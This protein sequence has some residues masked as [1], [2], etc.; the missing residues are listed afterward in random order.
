MR[1]SE[2][3]KKSSSNN[4][5]QISTDDLTLSQKG[6]DNDKIL[7]IHSTAMTNLLR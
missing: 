5:N 4:E 7:T 1:C 2:K 6:H 3:K